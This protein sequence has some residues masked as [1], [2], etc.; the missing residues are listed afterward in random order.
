MSIK[1][2]VFVV[3]NETGAALARKL[4]PKVPGSEVHGLKGRVT[5]ADIP[6]I[7][8]LDHLRGLFSEGRAIIAIVS[9]GIVIR[10]LAPLLADKTQEPAVLA[11]SEDGCSVVPLLGGHHGAND[12]A[13]IIAV[14]LDV[15]PAITTA[16]DSRF[17]VGLD[18]PPT[19]WQVANPNVAK[20]IMTALLNG[21]GVS[22]KDD[23]AK[24]INKNWLLEA[25]INFSEGAKPSIR[26]THARLPETTN[27]LILSPSILAL[28]IGC[29]RGIARNELEAFIHDTFIKYD[30]GINSLSCIATIDIKEDEAAI[31]FV[32]NRIDVPVRL[33]NAGELEKETPRVGSPSDYVFET[34]GTHSVSEAAALAAAGPNAKLIVSKQK[35]GG[36][37]CAVALS[38]NII[39]PDEVGRGCGRLAVIGIGPGT[40]DWR[41]PEATNEIVR[42]TDIVGY[43]LYLDLLGP[44]IDGKN[45]HSYLLGEERDR[46]AEA[47][48]L[49]AQGREVALVSS[50]DAGIYA[51]A[52]L[53]FELIEHGPMGEVKP[54]WQRLETHVV[55]G[56]S[57]LQA[58]A[59]KIGA[60]LGHD[61]CTVSLSDLL[62]PWHVI[63]RRLKAAA[64]GDFVIALYNPVSMK[65][66]E[67]LG[68]ARD[69]LL[70]ARPAETPVVLA[71]N[72]GREEE[73]VDVITLAELDA[74]LVDMLTVVLIG[75]SETR[76]FM[77]GNGQMSVY[78]P[79]G[80]GDKKESF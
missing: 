32:A 27:D 10:A 46:V 45:R 53:V 60:P 62:T 77:R 72:L 29:E 78:T 16:G 51:M 33:F 44:L 35:R 13:N 64:E 70:T 71:R 28:G 15:K 55:P 65:R 80:Y 42:A 58:A 54:E 22:L 48:N 40:N 56:I 9:A 21:E 50:G 36:M 41:A 59:A 43:Q 26:L 2:P 74:E 38:P 67:Q 11:L 7:K 73:K 39:L 52:C 14:V 8:T 63:E 24:S 6:F 68:I 12:L 31:R 3:L 25:G 47:L 75:S 30:L 37:T 79:R 34:V 5:K 57:A 17:G 18:N 49:A 4:V 23:T 76:A 66:R 19:G 69:I 1:S 61:F 20:P